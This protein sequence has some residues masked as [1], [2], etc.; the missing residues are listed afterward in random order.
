MKKVILPLTAILI[1]CMLFVISSAKPVFVGDVNGDS[2]VTAA[3]AR[4]VLRAAAR[5]DVLND[6]V[7]VTADADHDGSINAYDARLILRCAAGL[8][9]LG[10]IEDASE[11]PPSTDGE[12]AMMPEE[13]SSVFQEK[14]TE[15]VTVYLNEFMPDNGLELYVAGCEVKKQDGFVFVYKDEIY[16]HDGGHK[17]TGDDSVLNYL[18][19]LRSDLL[20]ENADINDENYKLKITVILSH[21]HTDHMNTYI[22]DIIPSPFIEID[23][24]YLTTQSV[25]ENTELYKIC[26]P[27]YYSDGVVETKGRLKFLRMLNKYS[28]ETEIIYLDFGETM[29]I[30]SKDNKL[31]FDLFAPSE[32]WGTAERAQH[33]LD[34]Y[35]DSGKASNTAADYPK[36]VVNSNSMWL[37]V[38][39]GER[40][41]LFTGDVMKRAS[42]DYSSEAE[43]YADEPFD[44]MLSYYAEKCGEDVFDVDLVKFPHHGQVRPEASKGVFEV[45]RPEMVICTAT[46]FRETTIANAQEFWNKYEGCY[47]VSDDMGLYVYT[48]GKSVTVSKGL[49]TIEVYDYEGKFAG[50]SGEIL[51]SS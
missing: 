5:L 22:H 31:V 18:M 41:M 26:D 46:S 14:N 19:N 28:P 12:G 36:A 1:M 2:T 39:Y 49:Q 37:K 29:Q 25:F 23:R 16:I 15:P 4:L 44:V 42:H 3:D 30:S 50:I 43:N 47:T 35:Y 24:V 48:D 7:S 21:F 32:D 9:N 40:T 11:T 51:L 13:E 45:L 17:D 6:S 27:Y 33:L 10:I 20:P 38:T 8:E 34:I